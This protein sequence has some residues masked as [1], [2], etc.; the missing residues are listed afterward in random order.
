MAAGEVA[1]GRA[2]DVA[3]VVAVCAAAGKEGCLVTLV[4][5]WSVVSSCAV[6][7]LEGALVVSWSVVSSAV[8]KLEAA[9]A[10]GV[11]VGAPVAVVSSAVVK[12]EAAVVGVAA[13][14]VS[15]AAGCLAW[16]ST[17]VSPVPR[18]SVSLPPVPA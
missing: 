17:P 5:S 3:A 16:H 12:L 14:V 8:V 15:G 4:V 13:T 6:V 7:K 18:V 10:I 11:G 9:V 2:V 1:A